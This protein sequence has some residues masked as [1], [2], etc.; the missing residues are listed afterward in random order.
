MLT[1]AKVATALQTVLTSTAETAARQTGCVQRVRQFTGATLVHT[2]VLGWLAHP[3]A[4][5]VQLCQM[6]ATRGVL[7]TPQ[8]LDARFTPAAATCLKE[9]LR[10][11]VTEVVATEPAAL[12]LLDRFAAVVVQ[13]S[14]LIPLP[15]DLADTWRGCGGSQTASPA[16]SMTSGPRPT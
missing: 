6:A 1:V 11:A 13:D 8:G 2:L 10:A 16:A 14:T 5:L 12:P 15:D 7:I 9:V 4:T 3:A